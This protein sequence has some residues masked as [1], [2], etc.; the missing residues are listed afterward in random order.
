[1]PLNQIKV[2]VEFFESRFTDFGDTFLEKN[3]K[4]HYVGPLTSVF[5]ACL[6][7]WGSLNCIRKENFFEKEFL[8]P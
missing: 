2:V 8:T 7:L 1:M 4:N 3:S 5:Y 6:M